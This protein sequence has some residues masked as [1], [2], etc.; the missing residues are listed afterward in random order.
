MKVARYGEAFRRRVLAASDIPVHREVYGEPA[1]YLDPYDTQAVVQTVPALID[2][3]DAPERT[4]R[5]RSVGLEQSA[6]ICPSASCRNGRRF[7]TSWTLAAI[8][9]TRE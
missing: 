3:D 4:E 6:S 8:R 7:C 9:Q 2:S 5:R 1:L